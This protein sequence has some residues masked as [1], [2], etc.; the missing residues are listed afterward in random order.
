MANEIALKLAVDGEA[1]LK[2]ALSQ[3]NA[4]L[5]NLGS[6]MNASVTSMQGLASEEDLAAAKSDILGRTL[7]AQTQKYDLLQQR[8]DSARGRLDELGSSLEEAIRLHGED[9]TEAEK[10]Q[11]AYNKQ[12]ESVNKLGTQLNNAQA[13]INKTT[14]ALQG[15]GSGAEDAAGS[16]D[17]AGGAAVSFGDLLKANLLSEAITGGISTLANAAKDLAQNLIGSVGE[18]ASYGDTIDKQSQK[19][20]ISAE[21]YQEWDAVL[22]HSGSSI[23]ALQAPMRQ[24]TKLAEDDAKKF[25]ALGISAEAVAG[26]NQEELFGEVVA[27]L[28]QMEHGTERAAIAQEFL[29]RSAQ[30]LTPLLNTSAEDTQKMRDAVHDLGG[31]LSDDA[32]K[33]SA[34][35]QDQLQDMNTAISGLKNSF[36][37]N[38]LPAATEVMGG[39]TDIFGGN[40][41]GADR[42]ADGIEQIIGAVSSG[43]PRLLEAGGQIIGSIADGITRRLPDIAQAAVEMIS[44]FST[45]SAEALPQVLEVGGQVLGA[46]VTGI[47]GALPSLIESAADSL[48]AFAETIS[49][50]ENLSGTV[51]A[52]GEII[53]ALVEG[54]C[55]ALPK[56]IAAAPTILLN[57]GEGIIQSLPLAKEKGDEILASIIDG[58]IGSLPFAVEAGVEVVGSIKAGLGDVPAQFIQVGRDVLAGIW[59]GISD[60]VAWLKS[61]VGGVVDRIKSWFTGS[62]GFDTHSPS[63]WSAELF[64]N[65]MAGA[66]EGIR[67]GLGG[68]LTAASTAAGEIKRTISGTDFSAGVTVSAGAIT[69]TLPQYASPAPAMAMAG[70]Y[71]APPRPIN[72]NVYS[73][74]GG[75]TVA[76]EQR[77]YT[78]A[79]DRR[80][81]ESYTQRKGR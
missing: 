21:A 38:L 67:D 32:V 75:R 74:V 7:E 6:E 14:A 53:G 40:G 57:L 28:Q 33:A 71:A 11:I 79:E 64:G 34:A 43:A 77:T 63:K 27:R 78:D 17:K 19:L 41:A 10:A 68:V 36:V 15:V 65:V 72:V 50:P 48:I 29:G 76:Y 5:K 23:S 30:E 24:L 31:V 16:F 9:S 35:F 18:L 61:Q 58:V 3:V 4:E 59:S 66:G 44:D 49:E 62:E 39:I 13:D 70:G 51:D 20:G 46:V 8:Y 69:G 37:S 25:E 80:V 2:S 52:A 1:Q 42:I 81:G 47:T 45:S 54:I 56:L 73:Q 60:K 55:R 12:A 26:M 22:Q